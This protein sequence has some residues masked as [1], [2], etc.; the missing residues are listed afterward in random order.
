[1]FANPSEIEVIK[2]IVRVRYHTSGEKIQMDLFSNS[3]HKENG[4]RTAR[5]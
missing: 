4:D 5:C 3:D 2:T 1:M